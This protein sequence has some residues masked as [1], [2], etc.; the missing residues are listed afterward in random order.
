MLLTGFIVSGCSHNM[1]ITNSEDYFAQPTAPVRQAIKLGVT[2]SSISEPLNSRYISAIV[3]A[4]QKNGSIERVIYP[5]N[6][7]TH[8][9]LVDAVVDISVK[10]RYDGKRSN[11]F[12]NWPGFL[13]FAPAIWGYGYNAEIETQASIASMKDG[14]SH[15]ITVPT[16]YEFR[17]ADMGRT[18]TEVGWF[19]VGI[20]PL[21]GGFV[22]TG[23]DDSI[24][25]E[26]IKNVSPS[27]GPYVAKKI[28][29]AA[30]DCLDIH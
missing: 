13:I 24:T 10:T 17:H 23:Y 15:L 30:C 2:S 28:V 5:Y 20:I 12:V 18:W 16:R 8:K 19:E 25:G 6:Q 9:D 7:A 27:Y 3:D 11:F 14:K 26:F 29:E 22:F 21:I 4:L 1:H